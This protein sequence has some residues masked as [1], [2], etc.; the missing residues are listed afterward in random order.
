MRAHG[1]RAAHPS[2][3]MLTNGTLTTRIVDRYE[4]IE[5]IGQGG[6]GTVYRAR[7]LFLENDVALKLLHSH[8]RSDEASLDRFW[9]EAKAA[10]MTK[11]ENLVPLLD[12]GVSR[13]G[14]HFLVMELIQG[15]TLAKVIE[16]GKQVDP[17]CAALIARQIA[18][19]LD[20]LHQLGVFHRDLKPANIMLC[21]GGGECPVVKILDFGLAGF[22]SDAEKERLTIPGLIS[23]TPAYMSPEQILGDRGDTRSDLYALGVV[24]YEALAGYVPFSGDAKQVLTGHLIMSPR[25]IEDAGPLGDL[26]IALLAKDARDRP[27]SAREV[28]EMLDTFLELGTLSRPDPWDRWFEDDELEVVSVQEAFP[29]KGTKRRAGPFVASI[30]AV[31]LGGLAGA[32]FASV[33]LHF[34]SPIVIEHGEAEP[35]ALKEHPAAHRETNVCPFDASCGQSPP[36]RASPQA[37]T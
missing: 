35:P 19:A 6:V 29:K 34:R 2:A 27:A 9:R 23:G 15:E 8:Y 32:Y 22:E 20:H 36:Q 17:R 30:L 3:A 10:S 14:Q 18:S 24:L 4:I 28:I 16:G 37:Q 25:E 1:M 7:N 31:I 12:Y 33:K 26:A 11:H 21:D 13:D 5:K